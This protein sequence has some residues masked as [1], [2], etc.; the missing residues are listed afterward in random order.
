MRTARAVAALTVCGTFG[1]LARENLAD[2]RAALGVLS[3]LVVLSW[4]LAEVADWRVRVGRRRQDDRIRQAHTEEVLE[5]GWQE[6]A[7]RMESWARAGYAGTWED[8][9]PSI[10][11]ELYPKWGV[12]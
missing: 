5:L 7:A 11:W 8:Y 3:T 9:Q 1:W 2:G 6:T 10:D 12:S 4:V